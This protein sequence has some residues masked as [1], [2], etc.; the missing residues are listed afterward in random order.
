MMAGRYFFAIDLPTEYKSRIWE[1]VEPLQSTHSGAKWVRR[2]N[3]HL[4]LLF[5]GNQDDRAVQA[6][7]RQMRG[8]AGSWPPF[9]LGL[10]GF[11]GFPNS[12]RAKVLYIGVGEGAEAVTNLA[13]EL[14]ERSK[15]TEPKFHPHLT[16]ARFKAPVP[17]SVAVRFEPI[18]IPVKVVSLFSSTLTPSG[19]IYRAVDKFSLSGIA[20]GE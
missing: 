10:T 7:S 15:V 8:L 19:P 2:D 1:I 14:Q 18:L 16:V 13:T 4:T 6:A 5:M 20:R 3:Y 12:N 9:S 17:I 11:G